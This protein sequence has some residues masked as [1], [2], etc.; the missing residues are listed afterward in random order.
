MKIKNFI[1]IAMALLM[2]CSL[3]AQQ[4][5]PVIKAHS[6]EA[7]IMEDGV[8]KCTWYIKPEIGLDIWNAS[9]KEVTLYTD[10]DSI[11]FA[12]DPKVKTYNF[13]ILL[14]EKDSAFTQIRYQNPSKNKDI[15]EFFVFD[16]FTTIST[17]KPENFNP[18]AINQGFR[19]SISYPIT[20]GRSNFSLGVGVGMAFYN[21]YIDALPKD[22]LPVAMWDE[23]SNDSYFVKTD[24]ITDPK[25]SYKKNK[26]TLTYLDIPVELRYYNK[27]GFHVSAG[28][29]VDFLVNS[30]FKFKGTDF[31]FGKDEDIKIK[32]YH[33]KNLSVV[34]AGPIVRVGWKKFGAYAT[35]SI[36]SVYNKDMDNKLNPICVGITFMPLY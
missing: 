32:K 13:I 18:R 20:F 1:L 24:N 8:R 12:V 34:Q 29:K 26:M 16:L 36:T 21:Y 19:F 6:D 30:Y 5:L 15:K 31:L 35:Y 25:I 10:L 3:F 28:A 17:N 2:Q 11:T 22:M 7:Y 33:L 4:E 27:K 9:G 14:N 23:Y